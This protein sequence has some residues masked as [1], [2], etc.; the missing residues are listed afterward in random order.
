[1]KFLIDAQLP[2]QLAFEL[3]LAG[4]EAR[5]TSSLR[6]GNASSDQYLLQ[7]AE[8]EG[9]VLMTKDRDFQDSFL[10]SHRPP[11]LL[12]ITTGNI[13][14]ATLSALLFK[15]L[16][17]LITAFKSYSFLELDKNNLIIHS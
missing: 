7:I 11:K 2:R 5:H 15:H 12:L 13:S 6:K 14:N 1:M 17:R 9:R 16:D 3:A 10:L 4:H 8:A